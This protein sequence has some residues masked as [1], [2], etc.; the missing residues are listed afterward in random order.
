VAGEVEQPHHARAQSVAEF[1]YQPGHVLQ[2]LL[3]VAHHLEAQL[4]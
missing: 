4:G 1:A 3:V 2:A